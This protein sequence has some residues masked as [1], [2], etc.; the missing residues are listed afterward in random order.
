MGVDGTSASSYGRLDASVPEGVYEAG[1]ISTVRIVIRNPFD[2]P[3][4]ILDIQGPRSSH[5]RHVRPPANGTCDAEEQE[6]KDGLW[7][8]ITRML[9]S[10]GAAAAGIA[11]SEVRFGGVHAVF[12]ERRKSLNI[13]AQPQSEIDI[14]EDLDLYDS[15]NVSADEGSKVFIKPRSPESQEGSAASTIVQPHCETVAYFEISSTGWLFFSPMRQSLST[16]ITYVVDGQ[17]RTQVVTSEFEIKPPLAS[18]VAGSIC[19]AFLGALAKELTTQPLSS[20]QSMAV[21]VGGA[22]VMSLI[23]TVALARKTGAQGF[24][25]V[26]DFF[27]GFVVGAL[28]GYGGKEYFENAIAPGSEAA[29]P[30]NN[31]MQPTGEIAGG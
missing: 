13:S 9:G 12:P 7:K 15:V 25:T 16:K 27:G 8:R 31:A 6:G 30:P 20:W 11:V 14:I 17:E 23:A 4:E 18:M 26:E 1:K 19:G 21:S 2:V 29:A 28:I 5:L 24:I 3:V 10:V 22:V